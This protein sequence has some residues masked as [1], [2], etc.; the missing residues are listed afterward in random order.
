VKFSISRPGSPGT[1]VNPRTNS[2]Q[3]SFVAV[4]SGVVT[5]L[6]NSVST[7]GNTI[8]KRLSKTLYVAVAG[9]TCVQFS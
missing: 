1:V 2:S 3:I 7:R 6:M 5:T 8:S 4:V 9:V